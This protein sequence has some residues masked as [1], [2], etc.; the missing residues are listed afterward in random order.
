MKASGEGGKA[1][2]KGGKEKRTQVTTTPNKALKHNP[3]CNLCDVPGHAKNNCPRLPHVKSMVL[4]TQPNL[5]I[6]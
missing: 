6:A 2:K 3:P 5:D 1:Q 4:D